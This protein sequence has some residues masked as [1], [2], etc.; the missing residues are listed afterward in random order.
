MPKYLLLRHP[1]HNRV[2]FESS[3]PLAYAELKAAMGLLGLEEAAPVHEVIGG[4]SYL[5]L[6]TS[7]ELKEEQLRLL[8]SLSFVLA[9][10]QVSSG[11]SSG[12]PPL[13]APLDHPFSFTMDEKISSLSRYSGKTNELFTRFLISVAACT[14]EFDP[15]SRLKL[16][17]PVSGRGTTLFEAALKGYDAYGVE[18]QKKSVHEA[19]GFLKTYLKKEGWKIQV[20]RKQVAG[21]KRSEAVYMERVEYARDRNALSDSENPPLGIGQICGDTQILD[22]YFARELF[23][24]IVGDLPYGIQHGSKVSRPKDKSATTFHRNPSELL[25]QALPAW[26]SVLRKGGTITLAW[27]ARVSS[28]SEMLSATS[29]VPVRPVEGE[30]WNRLT[31]KVDQSIL[32]DVL[33]LKKI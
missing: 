14:S 33:I 6:Q 26:V 20:E 15:L 3:L 23:D 30:H 28:R 8:G 9:L 12:G 22:K 16:L 18:I 31:H 4:L 32:R 19:H 5:G 21:R 1:G 2:Y 7:S 24:L 10:F 25:R 11:L 29:G 13:L 27:N 17:D